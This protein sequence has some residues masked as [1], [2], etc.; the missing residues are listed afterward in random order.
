MPRRYP[1]TREATKRDLLLHQPAADI[2][3]T[4]VIPEREGDEV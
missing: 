1:H 2:W 3:V 4:P